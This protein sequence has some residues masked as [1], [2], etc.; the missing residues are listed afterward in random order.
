MASGHVNRTSTPNTW[1]HRPRLQREDSSCQPGA[2][3]TWHKC[4][5]PRCPLYRRYRGQSGSD[6]DIV[7]LTRLTH[8][9]RWMFG[10]MLGSDDR[11]SYRKLRLELLCCP[12]V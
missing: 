3:H 4:E 1:Q 8:S 2:V 12:T 5:M 11:E 10:R 9:R 6:S 7:K